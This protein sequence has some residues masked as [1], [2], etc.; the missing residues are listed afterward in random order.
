MGEGHG[1]PALSTYRV[2]RSTIA[3]HSLWPRSP[4]SLYVGLRPILR[5]A[6]ERAQRQKEH[7]LDEVE[8]VITKEDWSTVGSRARAVLRLVQKKLGF[9]YRFDVVPL[10]P[11]RVKGSHGLRPAP[12]DGPVVIGPEPPDDMKGFKDYIRALLAT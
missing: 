5:M 6:G 2:R 8:E 1:W 10:D 4:G 3:P 11:G 7:L 9:R 12:E